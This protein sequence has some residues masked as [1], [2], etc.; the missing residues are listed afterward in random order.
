MTPEQLCT[1]VAERLARYVPFF[2]PTV[3]HTDE[4][5]DST[6][7]LV[8]TAIDIETGIMAYTEDDVWRVGVL[9]VEDD[10]SQQG[11]I[12]CDIA[13]ADTDAAADFIVE[14]ARRYY[15][16]DYLAPVAPDAPA[17]EGILVE[18]LAQIEADRV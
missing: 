18:V 16:G 17:R 1:A 13:A 3:A 4:S 9:R 12:D 10:G 7:W 6:D 8:Q 15:R 5:G 11:V 14:S 2:N